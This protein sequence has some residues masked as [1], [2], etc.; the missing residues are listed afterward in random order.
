MN[1]DDAGPDP[2]P[3]FHLDADQIRILHPSV[4]VNMVENWNFLL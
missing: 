4:A 2:D 1:Y 3:I